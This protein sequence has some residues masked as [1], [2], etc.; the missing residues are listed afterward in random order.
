M[1]KGGK[2]CTSESQ[3]TVRKNMAAEIL[4]QYL[5]NQTK[6]T[7]H[8]ERYVITAVVLII[9]SLLPTNLNDLQILF[10]FFLFVFCLFSF[11]YTLFKK[12]RAN[13]TIRTNRHRFPI[14]GLDY[15]LSISM[16]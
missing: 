11:I 12:F 1:Q 5:A 8:I 9:K 10:G 2:T 16:R 15:S 3:P 13:C 6:P 4:P 14:G 7:G